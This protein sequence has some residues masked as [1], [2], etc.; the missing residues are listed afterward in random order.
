MPRWRNPPPMTT[1]KPHTERS[2]QQ[3]W[4]GNS[5]WY[6]S[7]CSGRYNCVPFHEPPHVQVP[8]TPVSL[9][10]LHR[11]WT[12]WQACW[13]WSRLAAGSCPAFPSR[14]PHLPRM[15]C[16]PSTSL[17]FLQAPKGPLQ[18]PCLCSCLVLAVFVCG[19]LSLLACLHCAPPLWIFPGLS[20]AS[21]AAP[22]LFWSLCL[23]P[24]ATPA[25]FDHLCHVWFSLCL[26]SCPFLWEFE[27]EV[28][29]LA[30]SFS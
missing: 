3:S 18:A 25:L 26:K 24:F 30:F 23:N 21:G 20:A 13:R 19:G 5:E 15:H 22:S 1:Q 10:G 8:R 17:C 29:Y 14:H 11:S 27:V 28:V 2:A 16:S 6:L 7:L 4:R 9:L 12:G